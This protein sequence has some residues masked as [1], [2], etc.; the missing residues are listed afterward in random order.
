MLYCVSFGK[1]HSFR[2]LTHYIFHCHWV[3][4][5]ILVVSER[6]PI[7][8]H[9]VL[10]FF[11]KLLFVDLASCIPP[12]EDFKSRILRPSPLFPSPRR[13]DQPPNKENYCHNHNDPKS[14]HNDRPKPSHPISPAHSMSAIPRPIC[15]DH[16]R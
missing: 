14:N 7:K 3:W 1:N 9:Q 5:N 6:S 8:L 13:F 12:L 4:P 2:K 11:L 10:L 15:A 16:Q